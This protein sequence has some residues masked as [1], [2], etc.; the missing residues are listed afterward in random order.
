MLA[1]VLRRLDPR[2][3]YVQDKG[4][5]RAYNGYS[6]AAR[7]DFVHSIIELAAKRD[8]QELFVSEIVDS[9]VVKVAKE[10]Q[11]E[12][13]NRLSHTATPLRANRKGS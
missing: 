1:D 5:R 6:M 2:V 11:E 7:M 9:D 4:A 12:F 10:L 13:R 3:Y 8:S